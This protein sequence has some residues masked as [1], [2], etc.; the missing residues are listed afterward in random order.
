MKMYSLF[1]KKSVTYYTPFFQENDS[2]TLR[3]L[4]AAVNA[5]QKSVL[6][7]DPSDFDCYCHGEFH[8]KEG[9]ISCERTFICNLADLV[10]PDELKKPKLDQSVFSAQIGEEA[11]VPDED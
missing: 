3:A 5:D 11:E 4:K 8:N 1:D 6:T 7:T 10:V 9:L 2:C